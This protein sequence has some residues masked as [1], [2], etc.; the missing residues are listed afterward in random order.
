MSK[1]F[2]EVPTTLE[3][4]IN[5]EHSVW[6]DGKYISLDEGDY[7]TVFIGHYSDSYIDINGNEMKSTRAYPIRI[8]KPISRDKLINAAEMNEYNLVTAMDVASFNAALARKTRDDEDSTE[9]KEHDD[10]INWIKSE[11]TKIGI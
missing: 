7:I 9:V 3:Q 1:N 5:K 8:S 11:L 2:I 10:F 4:D 6:F